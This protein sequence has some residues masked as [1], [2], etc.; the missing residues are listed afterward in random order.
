M[1]PLRVTSLQAPHADGFCRRLT[2]Y[3]AD[4]L[5]RASRFIDDRPWQARLRALERG[6]I[7]LAWMCG[8]QYVQ[9]RD[10]AV[11]SL[12]PL[13]C[14]VPDGPRYRDRPVYFS[15]VIVRRESPWQSFD[16]L[17]GAHWAYNEPS[18]HSGHGITRYAMARAGL[19]RDFF[20]TVTRVGSHEAAVEW[21]MSGR[22][23]GAAID[24]TVLEWLSAARLGLSR[25]LR[26]IARWGPSP[27]PPWVA[28]G[29]IDA[30]TRA[31]VKGVLTSMHD[32]AGGRALLR[33]MRTARLCPVSDDDYDPIRRM[34]RASRAISL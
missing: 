17:A 11:G 23:D 20:G 13:A 15:D 29:R 12:A 10:A 30:E 9:K 2:T 31:A 21:V 26:V 22:A 6:D 27:A 19:G 25:G 3:L 16:E 8:L 24:S 33:S 28:A 18:S 4:R 34:A 1:D 32:D 7:D 14:P 5:G